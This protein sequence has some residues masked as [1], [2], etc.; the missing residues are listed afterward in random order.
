[1]T[2]ALFRRSVFGDT[3]SVT[4]FTDGLVMPLP[5][6]VSMLGMAIRVEPG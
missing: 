4:R 6:I 1:V 3:R 5:P 2:L